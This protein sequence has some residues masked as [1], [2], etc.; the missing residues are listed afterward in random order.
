[1]QMLKEAFII[2]V[3][4]YKERKFPRIPFKVYVLSDPQ[5]F[6]KRRKTEIFF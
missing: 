5:E 1:M 6:L 4:K 3:G 2:L